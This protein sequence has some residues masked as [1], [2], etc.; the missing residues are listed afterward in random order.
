VCR[1]IRS[2]TNNDAAVVARA[3]RHD[4]EGI[5][6]KRKADPYEPRSRWIKIK[7]PRYSQAQGRGELFNPPKTAR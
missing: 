6:A 7:N 3:Q 1:Q 2:R 4:I 5:V